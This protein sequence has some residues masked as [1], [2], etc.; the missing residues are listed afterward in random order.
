M[1]PRKPSNKPISNLNFPSFESNPRL[2]YMQ[3]HWTK[4]W[5]NHEAPC[6]TKYTRKI[7]KYRNASL[8]CLTELI[9]SD[10]GCNPLPVDL[11]AHGARL[12]CTD[13]EHI[14]SLCV[15][16][17]PLP[18][19]VIPGGNVWLECRTDGTWNADVN[20]LQPSCL[21]EFWALSVPYK[22]HCLFCKVFLLTKEF[23]E[24]NVTVL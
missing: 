8:L 7:L 22:V 5:R 23:Q 24:R 6:F 16:Y 15:I 21:G 20:S 4:E 2:L 14:G 3:L 11:I 19:F 1:L 17:C 10:S 13:S 18:G 12:F 9:V